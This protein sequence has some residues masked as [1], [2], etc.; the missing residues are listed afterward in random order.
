M[1]PVP[2]LQLP[3]GLG[4]SHAIE[5][6]VAHIGIIMLPRMKKQFLIRRFILF[7]VFMNRPANHGSLDELGPGSDNSDNF[8]FFASSFNKWL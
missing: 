5:K 1:R 2:A 7:V 4:D 3:G 8:H 6:D